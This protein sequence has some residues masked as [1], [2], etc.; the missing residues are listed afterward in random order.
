MNKATP[1]CLGLL[2]KGLFRLLHSITVLLSIGFVLLVIVLMLAAYGIPGEWV[3]AR[4]PINPDYTL[5]CE[6]IAF[7]LSRGIILERVTLH[8]TADNDLLA[9]FN[10]AAIGFRLNRPTPDWLSHIRAIE[11]HNLYV[12]QLHYIPGTPGATLDAPMPFP[13]LSTID[14]PQLRNVHVELHHVDALD[15]RIR[16]VVA[17]LYTNEGRIHFDAIKGIV[18]NEDEQIEGKVTLD[19]HDAKAVVNL[20]G[21]LYPDRVHGVYRALDFPLLEAYSSNFRLNAPAWANCTFSVG[22]NKWRDHFIF[23]IDLHARQGGTYCGVPFDSAEG[24][25]AC[26]G[27]FTTVTTIDPI[28]FRRNGYPDTTGSMVFDCP[29]DRFSFRAEGSSLTPSECFRI[30]DMPFTEAI[31]EI[32]TTKPPTLTLSGNIPFLSEQAPEFVVLDANI[33][34]NAPLSIATLSLNAIETKMSMR[35]GTLSFDDITAKLQSGGTLTGNAKLTIPHEAEYV[36]VAIEGTLEQVHLN[37]F[38]DTPASEEDALQTAVASGNVKLFCRTD[39]TLKQSIRGDY[40]LTIVSDCFQRLP[41]FA[42]LTDIIA[43]NIPGVSALTDT[44]EIKLV[45][46]ADKGLFTVPNFILT[47]TLIVIEGKASYDLPKDNLDARL[48]LGI[49]RSD[50]VMGTFSRWITAPVSRLMLEIAVKGS[51]SA[52]DWYPIHIV[53]KLINGGK[54]ALGF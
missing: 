28:V 41:L 51:L 30:I 31:P 26:R 54:S 23:D 46:T 9:S 8:Q 37:D 4:L 1:S 33:V 12:R 14:I 11:V 22:F 44:S 43:D 34:A 24:H 45:G 47:S 49:F 13:D 25:I 32:K 50:G 16:H 39:D 3:I 48:V 19:I 36:D 21:T 6:R 20:H 53:D 38:F 2:F 42:G 18:I 5:R 10:Q 15:V 35:D 27:V 7:T 52:P 40:D 29:K 17:N